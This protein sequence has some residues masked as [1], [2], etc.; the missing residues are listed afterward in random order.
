M[1]GNGHLVSRELQNYTGS[2]YFFVPAKIIRLFFI[3]IDYENT[4]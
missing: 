4:S 3:F 2:L 1:S